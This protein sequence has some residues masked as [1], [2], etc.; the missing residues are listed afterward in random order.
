MSALI[1]CLLIGGGL[2]AVLGWFGKCSTDTCPL[3]ANWRRGAIYGALFGIVFCFVTGVGSSAAMNRSTPNVKH[4]TG[5]E[6]ETE[7]IHSTKPVVVDFYAT[8]CSPCRILSPRL[9]KLAG[10]FTNEIKF[11]KINVDE[12]PALSQKFNIRGIPTLLFFKNGKV[13]DHILGLVET[14]DLKTHLESLAGKDASANG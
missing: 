8:S 2:G 10:A 4:I 9:D 5:A 13:M 3:I 6:F 7:V 12:A 14:D 11:V 1:L